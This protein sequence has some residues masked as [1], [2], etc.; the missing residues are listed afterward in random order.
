MRAP[1]Q[2]KET[3]LALKQ[4]FPILR[5]TIHGKPLVYLDSASSSQLPQVVIDA[6]VQYYSKD[7]ANVHR[8]VHTLSERA[9]AVYENTREQIRQF[10]NAEA[11]REVIF[12]KGATE[13]I[14]L[15]AQSYGR[16]FIKKGDEIILSVMEH[17][18]NLVPWQLFAEQSGAVLRVIPLSSRGELKLENYQSLLNFRTKMVAVT[19]VSN[20]LGTVNPIKEMIRLAHERQVPVLVDGAQA[21]AHLKVD[22]Q[23]LDCDFYVFSSHKTYGPTGVGVLYGKK[24]WLEQ[25]PPYQGGGDMIETVSFTKTTYNKLP[26]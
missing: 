5:Q 26:Y 21:L 7:H 2:K 13:G 15:I 25:L 11:S 1:I 17:H 9:T 4:D 10:I 24:A 20:V 16:R 8:G 23:E 14:N 12:V 22:V 3:E 6:L 18:S 19:Q